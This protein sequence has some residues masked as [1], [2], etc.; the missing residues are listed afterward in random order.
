VFIEFILISSKKQALLLSIYVGK[1][2]ILYRVNQDE[3]KI[4][5]LYATKS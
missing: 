1:F 5:V 4:K 3:K 2:R